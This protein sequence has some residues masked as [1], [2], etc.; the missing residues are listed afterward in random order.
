MAN[1]ATIFHR[2][3]K[4]AGLRN[5]LELRAV[6]SLTCISNPRITLAAGVPYAACAIGIL[7]DDETI[8]SREPHFVAHFVERKGI[9]KLCGNDLRQKT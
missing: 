8:F 5:Y 7:I 6:R 3:L 4:S 2:L 1:G 9:E